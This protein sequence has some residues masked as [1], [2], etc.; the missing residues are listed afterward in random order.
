MEDFYTMESF[1]VNEGKKEV[2]PKLFGDIAKNVASGF[3]KEYSRDKYHH[4]SRSQI[5]R[6]FNEVKRYDQKLDENPERYK[7]YR[8]EI[9][10][11]ISKVNYNVARAIDKKRSEEEVYKNLSKFISK[12]LNEKM[13]KDEKDYHVFTMLFEAVY[14]FYYSETVEKRIKGD[15]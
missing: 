1:Y 12:G 2:H 11:I 4:V 6:L 15:D 7:K 10:M 13:N 9:N 3:I 8:S 14:G 5:R